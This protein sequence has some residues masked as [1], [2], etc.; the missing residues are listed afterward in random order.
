ME[1]LPRSGRLVIGQY[2][3]PGLIVTDSS[4][5]VLASYQWGR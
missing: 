1:P 3:P 2:A 4:G 5:A